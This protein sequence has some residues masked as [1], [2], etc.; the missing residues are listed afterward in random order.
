MAAEE[1]QRTMSVVSMSDL[2]VVDRIVPRL[3]ARDKRQVLRTLATLVARDRP[4]R[5]EA[6]V[7]A[8]R[9][10][11]GIPVFG[12]STG[13][14][15]AHVLVPGLVKPLAAFARL[16]PAVNLGAADGSPSD[17]VVLLVSPQSAGDVHLRALAQLARRLRREHVRKELRAASSAESMYVVLISDEELMRRAAEPVR[18][19]ADATPDAAHAAARGTQGAR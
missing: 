18:E 1:V 9:S 14:A 5:K 13:V 12:P 3:R 10:G 17:L 16:D 6:I 4:A 2:F 8:V 15:L 19:P 11:T 7:E